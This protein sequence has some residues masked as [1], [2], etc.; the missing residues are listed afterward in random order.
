MDNQLVY[1]KSKNYRPIQRFINV[2]RNWVTVEKCSEF[3]TMVL[4]N[5]TALADV[6]TTRKLQ[7]NSTHSR[8][9]EHRTYTTAN[10]EN[11]HNNHQQNETFL[12]RVDRSFQAANF[13]YK[14]KDT[15]T[16]GGGGPPV[17]Y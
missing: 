16:H 2:K 1:Q 11:H 13:L 8:F 14:C 9:I 5:A 15:R 12:Q 6:Q 17:L 10:H 7:C 3:S 4:S